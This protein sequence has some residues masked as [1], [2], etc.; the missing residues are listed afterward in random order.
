LVTHVVICWQKHPGA[1][2]ERQALL[3]AAEP[4][5]AIPGVVSVTA[6]TMLPSTRPIVDTTWDV[7]YVITFVNADAFNAYQTNPDHVKLRQQVLEPNVRQIKVY[8]LAS[9]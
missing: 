6:G 7:A 2:N 8:D 5:R 1:A 3:A 4:L 9:P